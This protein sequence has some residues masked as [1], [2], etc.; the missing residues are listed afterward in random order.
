MRPEEHHREEYQQDAREY[1]HSWYL[2]IVTILTLFFLLINKNLFLDLPLLFLVFNFYFK[3]GLHISKFGKFFFYAFF[4]SFGFFALSLLYPAKELKSGEIYYVAKFVI[5]QSSLNAAFRTMIKL[6]FVSFVSMTS[7]TIINYTK[8]ILHLIV[9]KGLKLFW[10]YPALLAMNSIVLFKNEFERIRINAKLREL[11]L[12]DRIFLFFPLLVFAIRHSQR[13]A[14]ALVTRGLSEKKSF[15]F[16]Y[17]LSVADQL[18]F[19]SFLVIYLFLVG[20][21]IFFR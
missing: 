5:Y 9:H 15:Y 4:F 7:G 16:S 12:S 10:G 19:T 18:R 6:F 20:I 17:D 1:I 2:L 13:G 21:A 11:P 14:L 8:V 3:N